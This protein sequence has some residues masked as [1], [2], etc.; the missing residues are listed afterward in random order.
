MRWA[1]A[2]LVGEWVAAFLAVA[3]PGH[4]EEETKRKSGKSWR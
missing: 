2:G 4:R 3:A 1:K